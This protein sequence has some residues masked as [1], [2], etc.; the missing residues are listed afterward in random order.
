MPTITPTTT[1]KT[2][3]TSSIAPIMAAMPHPER[4]NPLPLKKTF[5]TFSMI[6]LLLRER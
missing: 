6:L 3:C 5:L 4:I 2:N 1:G